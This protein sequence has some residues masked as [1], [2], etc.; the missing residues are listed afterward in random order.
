MNHFPNEVTNV[1]SFWVDI[2]M[3]LQIMTIYQMLSY[4]GTT[5][6]CWL[7]SYK[8]LVGLLIGMPTQFLFSCIVFHLAIAPKST[9]TPTMATNT[10]FFSLK[11]VPNLTSSPVMETCQKHTNLSTQ[12]YVWLEWMIHF[13]IIDFKIISRVITRLDFSVKAIE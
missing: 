13:G 6:F 12:C 7:V 1:P 10:L 8:Y 4:T 2:C 9:Y 11:V 3:H 5:L